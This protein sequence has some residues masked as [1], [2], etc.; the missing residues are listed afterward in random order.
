MERG[1]LAPEGGGVGRGAGRP[2]LVGARCACGVRLQES[3]G[4]G[5]VYG[6]CVQRDGVIERGDFRSGERGSNCEDVRR[7]R[8]EV[9]ERGRRLRIGRGQVGRGKRG[10]GKGWG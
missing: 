6:S 10:I 2:A 5:D 3:R 4:A 1:C 8:R 7:L 9:R